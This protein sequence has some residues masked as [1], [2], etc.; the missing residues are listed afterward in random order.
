MTSDY[1]RIALDLGAKLAKSPLQIEA[2]GTLGLDHEALFAY[3]TNVEKLPEWLPFARTAKSDDSNA[4]TP[5]GVGS[6]RQIFT[7]GSKP[8]CERVVHFEAPRLYAY[9]ARDKD[10]FGAFTKHLGVISVEK[11]HVAGSVITWLA[12]G[13]ATRIV[14]LHYAGMRIVGHVLRKGIANLEKRFPAR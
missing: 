7:V 12:Y 3:V 4:E 10:L 1:G 5:S 13:E 2:Q 14:P 6:V 11:H 8:T 9:S